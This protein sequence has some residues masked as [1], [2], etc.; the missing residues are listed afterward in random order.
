MAT[1][2][3][4]K[5]S[6]SG[7]FLYAFIPSDAPQT[8]SFNGINGCEIYA[9][10]SGP[11]SLLVS[12]FKEKTIRPERK[13]LSIFHAVH[14]QL[15]EQTCFLPV[16]FGVIATSAPKLK[17]LI[18]LHQ[19]DFAEQLDKINNSVEM[20]LK[21]NWDV[22][23]IFEYFLAL[24][25]EIKQTRDEIMSKDVQ[26]IN[27]EDKMRVG[28]LFSEALEFE[29]KEQAEKMQAIFAD[30]AIDLVENPCR[31]DNEVLNFSYLINKN[32][33]GKF[34][35]C[36]I[37]ASQQFNDDFSIVYNGPWVPYSFVK[38]NIAGLN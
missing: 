19:Q 25:P 12:D 11:I 15:L 2:K 35:D 7:L 37:T 6:E 17:K 9:I 8:Y 33:M 3:I 26:D 34:E 27:F 30:I 28:Q 21:V 36:I 14:K 38:M 31:K 10:K 18:E 1:S 4:S 22:A 23:N 29:R 16:R 20:G 5:K 13:H 24:H 32:Q